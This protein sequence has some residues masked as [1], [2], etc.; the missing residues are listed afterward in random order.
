[1]HL[2]FGQRIIDRLRNK[3]FE[4][5]SVA[6]KAVCARRINDFHTLIL[7][8]SQMEYGYIPT[9]GEINLSSTSM[10]LYYTYAY[11][12]K[13]QHKHLDNVII[14]FSVFTPASSLIRTY[15]AGVTVLHKVL[16]NIDYQYPE[17]AKEKKLYSLEKWYKK[18][19]EKYIER[20]KFPDNYK[21]ELLQ[22]SEDIQR[23]PI[24]KVQ[25]R[26]LDHYK[27]NIRENHQMEYCEKILEETLKNNQKVYFVIPPC[28]EIYRKALPSNEILFESLNKM[29]SKYPHSKIINLYDC[30]AFTLNDFIDGDHLNKYGAE[31]MTQLVRDN[32]KSLNYKKTTEVVFCD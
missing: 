32:Q 22:Y 26:A 15:F 30:P 18:S 9:E 12:N 6:N 14:G 20:T 4:L 24:D 10:D 31:K 25:K 8:S 11:Y 23:A 28:S 19:A 17:I 13:F 1:M 7:G 16:N 27:N 21:G 2:I 5:P 3:I 29:C